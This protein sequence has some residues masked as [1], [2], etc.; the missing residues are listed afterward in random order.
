MVTSLMGSIL[1]N[2][3][4]VHVEGRGS[5]SDVCS[6]MCS[7]STS[8]RTAECYAALERKAQLY[9]KLGRLLALVVTHPLDNS[10]LS[11]A[12]H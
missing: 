11:C 6:C 10:M 9:E 7:Q 1:S 3:L 5:G 4:L 8:D 12:A 2:L